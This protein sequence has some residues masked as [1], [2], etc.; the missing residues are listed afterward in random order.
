MALARVLIALVLV[1]VFFVL[2]ASAVD[3]AFIDSGQA[4]EITGESLNTGGIG[5]VEELDKSKL[6]GVNYV[7]TV[8]IKNGS[9][10]IMVGSGTDYTWFQKNGTFKVESAELAN[11]NGVTVDYGYTVPNQQ[12]TEFAST[13]GNMIDGTAPIVIWVLAVTAII[14]AM[15]RLGGL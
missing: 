1:A 10:V 9:D 5:T 6:S 11:D 3:Q 14:G 2:G 7:K 13:F 8:S 15:V 4:E 12:Q